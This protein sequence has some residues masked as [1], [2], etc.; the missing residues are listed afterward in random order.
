M[1][2]VALAAAAPLTT[3]VF[4][5]SRRS[6]PGFFMIVS[7]LR[8][9]SCSDV[10]V[11]PS[12][13]LLTWPGKAGFGPLLRRPLMAGRHFY[14][15]AASCLQLKRPSCLR[16]RSDRLATAAKSGGGVPPISAEGPSSIDLGVAGSMLRGFSTPT[17][18]SRE[19]YR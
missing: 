9:K 12:M 1:V 15:A 3:A 14:E 18:F 8:P 7:P 11:G 2:A 17:R 13:L 5:K 19:S 10:F 6:S 16:R 4:R